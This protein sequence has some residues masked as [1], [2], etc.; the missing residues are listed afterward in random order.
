MFSIGD[1][2]YVREDLGINK[3]DFSN[4]NYLGA[5][6]VV[7]ATREITWSSCDDVLVEVLLDGDPNPK[8]WF[9]IRLGHCLSGTPDWEV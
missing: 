3:K 5:Q 7:I 9:S 4:T 1:R 8:E 6:G 2:I